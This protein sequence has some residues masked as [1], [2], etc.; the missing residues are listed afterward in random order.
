MPGGEQAAQAGPAVTTVEH[1][2]RTC[3]LCRQA[4]A[5]AGLH[6]AW[7]RVVALVV[8][9]G[10]EFGEA[11]VFDYRRAPAAL[12]LARAV[13]DLPHLVYEAH[14]TDYQTPQA[15]RALVEDHFAV[16]KVGPALTYAM[17]EALFALAAIEEE[18]FGRSPGGWAVVQPSHLRATLDRVMREHPDHWRVYYAGDEAASRLARDFSYSDRIRYYWHQRDVRDAVERLMANLSEHP[19][20]ATLLSQFLPD[21]ARAARCG[22]L[23]AQPSPHELIRHKI[24]AVLDAYAAAC[25]MR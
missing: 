24:L 21:E 4:F 12:A 10:V 3:E 9:P 20:P 17:R 2:R 11:V 6:H 15:L 1:A 19:V 23:P 13:K 14:S 16:L 8:Q 22:E 18:L 25:G 7:D 5:G